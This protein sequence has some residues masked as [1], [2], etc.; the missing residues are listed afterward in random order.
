M[1]L[2]KNRWEA[3]AAHFA[4]SLLLLLGPLAV[5]ILFWYPGALFAAA[6]GWQGTRIMVM[7]ALVTGPLLTLAVFS[8][9]KPRRLLNRDLLIIG[10]IQ[11][12][13]LLAGVMILYAERPVAVIYSI[14]KFYA[15]KRSEFAANGK[16]PKELHLS[17]MSPVYFQV[18]LGAGSREEALLLNNLNL[19]AGKNILFRNDLYKPLP[20]NMA[21]AR[22]A[23]RFSKLSQSPVH[24]DRCLT[25]ELVTSYE[26]DVVCFDPV[27]QRLEKIIR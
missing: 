1:K 15:L 9:A 21:E 8:H 10:G 3:F 25:A 16:D 18:D 20:R 17:L 23:L 14:D 22:N 11:L 6:G 7:V 26:E 5:V 4:I 13:S 19:M 24:P 2:P 27:Q 12:S